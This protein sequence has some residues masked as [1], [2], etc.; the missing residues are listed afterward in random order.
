LDLVQT[1]AVA[2]RKLLTD[3]F[4]RSPCLCVC[5]CGGGGGGPVTYRG[6]RLTTK[7][8][9]R[10]TSAR[11]SE[12]CPAEY[13]WARFVKSTKK[14]DSTGLLTR[15]ALGLR[16]RRQTSTLNQH[17]YLPSCRT[18]VFPTSA[19]FQAKLSVRALMWSAKNGTPKSS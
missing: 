19:N 1:G 10:I 13:C 17:R 3:T 12:R 5:V 6:I 2:R 16:V 8:K 18:T 11:V 14:V 4:V 15:V 7:E 9:S